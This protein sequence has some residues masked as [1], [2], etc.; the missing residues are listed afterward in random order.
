MSR[1]S[2]LSRAIGGSLENGEKRSQE[3]V[4]RGPLTWRERAEEALLVRHVGLDG[5]VDRRL[6]V[7]REP[8]ERAPAICRVG[9]AHDEAGLGQAVEALGHTARREHGRPHQ[10]GGVELVGRARPS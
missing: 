8:D 4:E 10:L 7:P 1:R 2:R 3:A 5:L 6:T 9:S